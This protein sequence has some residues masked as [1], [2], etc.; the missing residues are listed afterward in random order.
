[1]RKSAD[2]RRVSLQL[3]WPY[4]DEAERYSGIIFV[5]RVFRWSAACTH[6]ARLSHGM[7]V[8]SRH[9]VCPVRLRACTTFEA[10]SEMPADV[11]TAL[12]VI[13]SSFLEKRALPLY[14]DGERVHS[15]ID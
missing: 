7:R 6:G 12:C 11:I 3:I 13:W 14:A 2:K 5:E 9:R 8:P 4:A 1:M 10:S 15:I